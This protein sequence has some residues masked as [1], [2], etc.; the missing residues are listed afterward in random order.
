MNI[1]LYIFCFVMPTDTS[2]LCLH[3]DLD[4][5]AVP[6]SIDLITFFP[7]TLGFPLVALLVSC[8]FVQLDKSNK[9]NREHILSLPLT[10][11]ERFTLRRCR[12]PAWGGIMLTSKN[13]FWWE[14][15]TF[16]NAVLVLQEIVIKAMHAQSKKGGECRLT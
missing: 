13:N 3:P 4:L 5:S 11:Y 7:T 8:F 12:H 10:G 2:A 14:C 9:S 6:R 1:P 15:P 16:S